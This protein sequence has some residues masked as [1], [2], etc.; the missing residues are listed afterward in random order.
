MN[1]EFFTTDDIRGKGEA[2]GFIEVA[3]NTGKAFADWLPTM[4][5]VA[6]L[7]RGDVNDQIVGAIIEGVRLQGRDVIDAGSGDGQQVAELISA[8]GYSG[9]VIIGYDAIAE[10]STIELYNETGTR[11]DGEH[12]LQTIAESVNAGNFVPS[13]IKGELK[14]DIATR[15]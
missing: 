11:I 15:Q 9:A 3:W 10:V 13:R 5:E 1:E 7:R 2:D 8:A 12:G 4:G 14:N 6:V